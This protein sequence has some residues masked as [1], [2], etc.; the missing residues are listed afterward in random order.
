MILTFVVKTF[1]YYDVE[2]FFIITGPSLPKYCHEEGTK[3]SNQS[4]PACDET[5]RRDTFVG[6]N[7]RDACLKAGIV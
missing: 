3:D 7:K 2:S 4:L 5:G 6:H 1:S